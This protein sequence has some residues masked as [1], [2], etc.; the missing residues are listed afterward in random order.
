MSWKHQLNVATLHNVAVTSYSYFQLQCDKTF[1]AAA[2]C[3]SFAPRYY[4]LHHYQDDAD[5][6]LPLDA[7]LK[8]ELEWAQSR[9]QSQAYQQPALTLD[10][11]NPFERSLTF[12]EERFR[13]SYQN[14]KPG[15]AWQLNQNPDAGFGSSS[16]EQCLCTLISNVHMLYTERVTPA[17]W[18]CGSEALATQGFPVV[19]YLWG[20]SPKDFPLLSS[21][22][23][24]SPMRSSRRML[25]QAGN[26]MNV[27][28]MSV[29]SLHGLL[30]WQRRPVPPLLRGIGS[31]RSSVKVQKKAA[32]FEDPLPP[33]KRL[34]SK[35]PDESVSLEVPNEL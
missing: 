25:A 34:R 12:A 17:R 28:V 30:E 5:V 29:I 16:S 11:D 7:E 33:K 8:A 6:T 21:F 35:Q 2:A 22:N 26:S 31:A 4:Y 15:Q 1:A 23:M 20:I 18:M 27:M 3:V 19:P 9:P 10:S 32:N 14:I 24:P 13:S